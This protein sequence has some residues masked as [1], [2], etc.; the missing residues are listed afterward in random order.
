MMKIRK[1]YLCNGEAPCNRLRNGNRNEY[2]G[3]QCKHTHLVEYAK[4]PNEKRK[5]KIRKD[6]NGID[7]CWWE[8]EKGDTNDQ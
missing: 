2:C 5:Y 1:Y 6:Y 8:V 7:E 3:S 4:N